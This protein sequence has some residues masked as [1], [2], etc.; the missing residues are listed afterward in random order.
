MLAGPVAAPSFRRTKV[1]PARRRKGGVGEVMD[2][3][4]KVARSRLSGL[5]HTPADVNVDADSTTE[6]PRPSGLSR[7][8]SLTKLELRRVYSFGRGMDSYVAPPSGE[9]A[10]EHAEHLGSSEDYDWEE[11]WIPVEM[12]Y[13]LEYCEVP[14]RMRLPHIHGGYRLGG[15]WLDANRSLFRWHNETL[16][17]WTMILNDAWAVYLCYAAIT[18]PVAACATAT[19]MDALVF[20]CFG[21]HVLLHSF[22]SVQCHLN[23]SRVKGGSY[24]WHK[25]DVSFIFIAGILCCASQAWYLLPYEATAALLTIEF[26]IATGGTVK[27]CLTDYDYPAR[28]IDS[29]LAGMTTLVYLFPSLYIGSR[30]YV[31]TDGS[32]GLLLFAGLGA[33][34]ALFMGGLCFSMHFPE[35]LAPGKLDCTL[36]S[37]NILHV[38][39]WC[40]VFCEWLVVLEGFSLHH[41]IPRPNLADVILLRY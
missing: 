36:A 37:G 40:V 18:G 26:L 12:V 30:N 34:L 15:T 19:A 16:R 28:V 32:D 27:V 9:I 33:G 22:F 21:F 7:P 39:L 24:F 35:C 3:G 14:R 4:V 38:C 41:G 8:A 25:T 13:G 2:E 11:A 6:A 20:A 31:D 17:A 23:L 5:A 29:A 1:M 10:K